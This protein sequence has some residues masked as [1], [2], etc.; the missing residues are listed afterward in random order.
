M[1][2]KT[3]PLP[4]KVGVIGC[5]KISSAY[6]THIAPYAKYAQ[7]TACADLD[8][9]HAEAKASEHNIARVLSVE[10]LLADKDIDIVLNLTIPQAHAKLN[11]AA[12][13]A[14]KHVYCE[15]PFS[16][17]TAEGRKVLAEAK[18]RG[19]KVGCAPDTFLGG[20]IQTSR[21]VIAEGK[22]GTP[23]AATAFLA[24]PGHESWHP[25]PG[26]YYKAGGGPLFDMGPYYLTALIMMLGP[27]K[28]VAGFAKISRKQREITSKPLC[29]K[30]ILV[31]TPTHIT[32]A[33]ELTSGVTV[34][35]IMS[36][37]I[38]KHHL[39]MIEIHGTEGSLS[40]PD[41]NTFR[42]EVRLFRAGES[43]WKTVSAG[44]NNE[45]GRGYGVAEMAVAICKGRDNR[46]SGEMALHVVEVMES[47]LLSAAKGRAITLKTTCKKPAPLPTGLR[48]GQLK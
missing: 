11:L 19:L 13:R 36:F 10:E 42:G 9:S 33:L 23:L 38:H 24:C 17:N 37:D 4:M 41:P 25:N 43:D 47:I 29:G 21:R 1:S 44:Y 2:K 18:A 14:G 35:M 30:K 15:K 32:G 48:H 8:R 27:V 3:S 34:T 16:L 6:F 45:V 46:A 5:G 40:C 20:G 31:E 28:R 7:V 22:I 39:P 26:F 12:I